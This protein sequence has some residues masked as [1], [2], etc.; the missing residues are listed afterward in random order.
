LSLWEG[1]DLVIKTGDKKESEQANE[2]LD[3][4]KHDHKAW[5]STTDKHTINSTQESATFDGTTP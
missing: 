4:N 2:K 3:K 1:W 5:E